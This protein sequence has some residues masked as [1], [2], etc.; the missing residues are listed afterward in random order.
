MIFH[1]TSSEEWQKAL[2]RGDYQA[3]S[4]ETEGFIH[5]STSEQV[6]EVANAFYTGRP[7]LVVLCIALDRLTAPVRWEEPAHLETDH[8]PSVTPQEKFPHIYGALNL[9]AVTQVIPLTAAD[10]FIVLREI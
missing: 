6:I 10:D 2:E 7:N 9:D 3:A 8:L 4:L 1:I 5:C